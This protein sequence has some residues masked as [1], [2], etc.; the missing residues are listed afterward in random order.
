[1]DEQ[2]TED[3]ESAFEGT[4]DQTEDESVDTADE[5]KNED[6][7]QSK[8]RRSEVA[9][10]IKWREK[11]KVNETKVQTLEKELADLRELVKKPTDDQEAKAQEYIRAQARAVFEELQRATK[12]EEEKRT[13]QF[14]SE[15]DDLLEENPDVSEEELLDIIEE[16]DV[17]PATALRIY[18]RGS[19]SKKE[20][21]RL[22][23]AGRATPEAKKDLPDD[24]KK[25][26]F[27]I[28]RD[29]VAKIR[30]N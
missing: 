7:D 6:K 15:I 19:A 10:K 3:N 28:A 14:K 23:K 29:E 27:D 2:S 5:S 30:G 4:P 25:S 11:A 22:P 16:L 8:D 1:M 18:K 21:P 9:Q 20:K 13:A 12:G 24:S 26:I 17:D